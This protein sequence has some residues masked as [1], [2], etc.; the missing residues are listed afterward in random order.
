MNKTMIDEYNKVFYN[1]IHL[2]KKEP[3]WRG[4]RIIKFPTDLLL[5]QQAIWANKPDFIIETGTK[6]GGSAL[7]FAD[8]L[9]LT[10]K[11]KVIT[12][13]INAVNTPPHPRVTYLKGPST[14]ADILKQVREFVKDGTVMVVLDSNH[15]RRH[16]KRE[17]YYYGPMV[18]KNQYMVVEDCYTRG[19]KKYGPAEAIEWYLGRTRAFKREDVTAQFI[20]AITR[21]GWL[22]RV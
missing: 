13:D 6:F 3:T 16:V 2:Q 14:N 22:R 21:D 10:G 18:T 7:F 1:H 15:S 4:V 5:Y 19:D 20:I 12:V 9:E 8:M 17:L 11:G